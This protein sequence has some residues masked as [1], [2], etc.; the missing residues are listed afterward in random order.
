MLVLFLIIPKANTQVNFNEKN[1][2]LKIVMIKKYVEKY[3]SKLQGP[4]KFEWLKGQPDQLTYLL[5][6]L[7]C[8]GEIFQNIPF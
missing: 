5:F 4:Q 1:R 8:K 3:K 6:C 2:M 7:Y